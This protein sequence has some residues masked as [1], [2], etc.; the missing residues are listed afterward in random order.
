MALEYMDGG[1]LRSW[2]PA[3][4]GMAEPPLRVIASHILL[5]LEA[6]HEVGLR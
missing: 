3:A 5:G 2:M 6:L 4:V 1:S